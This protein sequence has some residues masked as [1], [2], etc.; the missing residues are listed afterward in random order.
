V[1]G[2]LAVV[3]FEFPS[4]RDPWLVAVIWAAV[5][6]LLATASVPIQ[7]G[8]FGVLGVPLA[9]LH[10]IAAGFALWVL[11]GTGYRI[12][13]RQ[14]VVRGGPFRWRIELDAIVSVT[15]TGSPLSS[16]ACSLDRLRIAYRTTRG[17]RTLMVSP[18]DKA[19]FLAA[20]ARHCPALSPASEGLAARA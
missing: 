12:E 3:A 10:G 20:L 18:A 7:S 19:G 5:A 11:Y 2:T 13:G 17:E 9:L 14:L 4:K 16:P 15:P 1:D 6:L 8:A